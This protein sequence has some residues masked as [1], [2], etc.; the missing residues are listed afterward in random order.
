MLELATAN[1]DGTL[2]IMAVVIDR[3]STDAIRRNGI[4]TSR[5]L[6]ALSPELAMINP[7]RD[8]AF[9]LGLSKI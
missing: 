6:V 2:S 4:Q 5:S 9:R 3:S 1:R 7:T 8:Q